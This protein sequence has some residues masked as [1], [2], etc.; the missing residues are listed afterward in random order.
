MGVVK[1]IKTIVWSTYSDDGTTVEFNVIY[2][3][4]GR[5]LTHDGDEFL[6]DG[7]FTPNY[8]VSMIHTYGFGVDI[9]TTLW[10]KIRNDGGKIGI[11]VEDNHIQT[12]SDGNPDKPLVFKIEIYD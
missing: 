4:T 1:K 7:T 5:N 6:L 11:Y 12:W 2:N 10:G 9:T 8:M 3:T